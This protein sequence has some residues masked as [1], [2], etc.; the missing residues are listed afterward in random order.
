MFESGWS[1][2]YLSLA[3]YIY[4]VKSGE[5]IDESVKR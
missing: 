4:R 3:I 1:F 5:E 2:H